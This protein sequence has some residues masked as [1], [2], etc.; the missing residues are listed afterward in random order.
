MLYD[1]SAIS[2]QR[3]PLSKQKDPTGVIEKLAS[4]WQA[5]VNNLPMAAA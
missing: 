1:V 4:K 3:Q 5:K 2:L